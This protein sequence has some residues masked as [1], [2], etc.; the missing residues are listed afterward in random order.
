M[1]DMRRLFFLAMLVLVG[2][3]GSGSGGGNNPP[4]AG[5]VIT[6]G[7]SGFTYSPSSLTVNVGDTVTWEGNFAVHPLV[8]GATCGQPDG[9]FS[10][11]S[12]SSFSYTFTAPGTY[13][14]YCN[15]H[16]GQGMTG[17]VTV[18]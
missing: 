17:V 15:V 2:C 10:N 12:G 9:K 8:S 16:C 3:G 5:N 7:T 13:P 6:F 18:R 11:S 14:Y 4:P 1:G